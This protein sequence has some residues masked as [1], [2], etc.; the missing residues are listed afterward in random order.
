M[1]P[2][3]AD[4]SCYPSGEVKSRRC[5]L[6]TVRKRRATDDFNRQRHR[7][8][9]NHRYRDGTLPGRLYSGALAI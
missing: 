3:D 9:L 1:P 8:P 4:S 2:I 5:A 7:L 6:I